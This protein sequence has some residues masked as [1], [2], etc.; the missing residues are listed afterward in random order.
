MT[1]KSALIMSVLLAGMH[2]TAH[3]IDLDMRMPV[4]QFFELKLP[5]AHGST[6]DLAAGPDRNLWVLQHNPARLLRVS[7]IGE[8]AK[9]PLPAGSTPH[10][11]V[12]DG[13]GQLWLA[14]KS[15]NTVAQVST[16]SGRIVKEF[17]VS[18]PERPDVG[19]ISLA[20]A[21]DGVTLWFAGNHGNL[22]GKL[23]TTSGEVTHYP[24]PAEGGK[25]TLVSLDAKGNLWFN[26]TEG[27][28]IGLINRDGF[29][30][31]FPAPEGS[32]APAAFAPDPKDN[33]M[34]FVLGGGG[35]FGHIDSTGAITVHP[36]PAGNARLST[37][38]FDRKGLL[39]LG[40]EAPDMVAV[41]AGQ[42]F[43]DKTPVVKE[44]TLPTVNAR[45]RRLIPGPDGNLWFVETATDK[46]GSVVNTDD[47][48]K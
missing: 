45:M 28:R 36:V 10:S 2:G 3:A 9:I 40:Y 26:Q 14:F 24:L 19:P 32:A 23:N 25:P 38:S 31:D 35:L 41:V 1:F 47:Y 11:P 21:A 33:R 22:V 4:H 8:L 18:Q 34:W 13:A 46:L 27:A 16:S 42:K 44:F 15:R 39:W 37:L 12:F 5:G 7:T 17:S 29:M 48:A 30:F 20:L 6:H 43:F